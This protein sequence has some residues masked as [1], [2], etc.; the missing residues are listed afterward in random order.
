MVFFNC[1]ACGES[2]KK[3]QVEKHYHQQCRS[4]QV[5]SCVDCG[6]EFWGNDYEQHTKCISEEEKFGGKNYKPKPNANKG[7]QKQELWV[8]QV[9]D[10]ISKLKTN[11]KLKSLLE[12]LKD[13]PNIPRKKAKFENFLNNS[14]R[15]M[16]RS[17]ASQAWDAISAEMNS[18]IAKDANDKQTEGNSEF[19]KIVESKEIKKGNKNENENKNQNKKENQNQKENKKENNENKNETENKIEKENKK[20]TK[21]EIE[22][23]TNKKLKLNKKKKEKQVEENLTD[24]TMNNEKKKKR[25]RSEMIEEN[26]AVNEEDSKDRKKKKKKKSEDEIECGLQEASHESL[27]LFEKK[28]K[29][30]EDNKTEMIFEEKEDER[31]D[32]KM[33]EETTE[34]EK[35]ES[36]KWDY[37][38]IGVLKRAKDCQISV[39]RLRKKVLCEY[40]ARGGDGKPYTETQ[41][42]AKFNK[43]VK[44]NPKVKLRKDVVRLVS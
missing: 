24:I 12:R 6:K 2:M 14:L 30:K 39:K 16:D 43:Q 26:E 44:K 29:R 20:K 15:V 21:D 4:C 3:N 10:A 22:E 27:I 18:V 35:R 42:L 34:V 38:I 11:P 25:K 17:L 7:E 33:E 36:F 28:K 41:L 8:T 1:N 5:L 37:A 40:Y 13:Y 31:G 32:K 23:E 19:N 9:Q